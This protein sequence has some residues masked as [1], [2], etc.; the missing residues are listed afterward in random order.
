MKDYGGG[1]VNGV[2]GNVMAIIYAQ[3]R[4]S[5]AWAVTSLC[6]YM[7]IKKIYAFTWVKN[8]KN[9]AQV[10]SNA[11]NKIIFTQESH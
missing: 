3:H 6:I 4:H 1:V 8:L 11:M 10:L 7:Q 2:D 5:N 9:N